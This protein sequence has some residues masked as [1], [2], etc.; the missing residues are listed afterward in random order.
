MKIDEER[1]T[2][3]VKEV[4]GDDITPDTDLFAEGR[5]DSYALISILSQLADMGIEIEPTAAGAESF[6]TLRKIIQLAEE[7]IR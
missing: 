5:M 7:T 1:I 2:Q 6:S 4:C 3:A